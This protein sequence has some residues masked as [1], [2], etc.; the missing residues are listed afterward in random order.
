MLKST[1]A[2]IDHVLSDSAISESQLECVVFFTFVFCNQTLII[3]MI[4]CDV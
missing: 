4:T 3:L 1:V 2:N